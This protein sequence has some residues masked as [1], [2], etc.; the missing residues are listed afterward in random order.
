MSYLFLETASGLHS[1]HACAGTG[2]EFKTPVAGKYQIQCWGAEARASG[3]YTCGTINLKTSYTL[4]V[5]AGDFVDG[6]IARELS[7]PA[8]FNGGG[9]FT[10][11]Q[12][13]YNNSTGG[14][15]TD[16]RLAGGEWNNFNSLKSRIMVAAGA[17]GSITPYQN[18]PFG[19][20][21]SSPLADGGER[22]SFPEYTTAEGCGQTYGYKFGEGETCIKKDGAGLARSGGGGGYYG[23][24]ANGCAGSGGSSFIS[25]YTGCNAISANST[26]N[27]IIHTGQPNHYSGLVFTK[28][29]MKSGAESHP[30]PYV[31]GTGSTYLG[32]GWAKMT[33]Q[34]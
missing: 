34:Y 18:A 5:Y 22:P 29:E 27:N 32:R 23:G 7:V 11:G 1:V 3:A 14:G 2:E 6:H 13:D 20:G 24:Y 8:V 33:W 16:I 12:V 4:F 28:A 31:G 21:L 10:V 19:G 30:I 15:A 25:G 9:G 17:G 26:E